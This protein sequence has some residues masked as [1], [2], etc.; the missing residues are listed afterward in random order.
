[1]V[2]ISVRYA[3]GPGK[4]DGVLILNSW[5]PNWVK[6]PKWPED[7]P[8]G[9]FWAARR[10]VEA[11]LAQGDSFVIAGAN[12][13]EARDLDNGAWLEPAAARPQTA[14]LIADTFSLAP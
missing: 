8:E 10:D 2:A 9:S 6:G 7:Q 4:R 13:F 3:T 14:R 1:M 5:G 11:M 12:G